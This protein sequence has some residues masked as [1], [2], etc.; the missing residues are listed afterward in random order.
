MAT[1]KEQLT[2]TEFSRRRILGAVL[3]PR[4]GEVGEGVPRPFRAYFVAGIVVVFALG[5]AAVVGYMNPKP[6][7]A[8]KKGLIADGSG[9][10]YVMLDGRLHPLLNGT[11]ARLLFGSTTKPVRPGDAQLAPYLR[12]LGPAVGLAKVPESLPSAADLDLKDFSACVTPEGKT[13]VEVGFPA[14][15]GPGLL[16]G[17]DALL[18]QDDAG[19][20]WVVE[21]GLKYRIGDRAVVAAAFATNGVHPRRVPA[22]WLSGLS[23]GDVLGIPT[24][25]GPYGGPD[26]RPAPAGFDKIG[27]F[28]KTFGPG[29]SVADYFLVTGD[30]VAAVTPTMYELYQRD[31]RLTQYKFTEAVLPAGKVTADMMVG[32]AAS[33]TLAWPVAPPRFSAEWQDAGTSGAAVVCATFAGTFDQQGRAHMEVAVRGALPAGAAGGGAAA[34]AASGGGSADLPSAVVRAGHGVIV[35]ESGSDPATA[36]E[37]LLADTGLRYELV[38]AAP[39]RLGYDGI[40]SCEVPAQWLRLVP[41]GTALDPSRA[42]TPVG[43]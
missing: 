22:A 41:L 37:Y 26:P 17:P 38:D 24:I 31:P 40:A 9:T 42:A 23:A 12:E 35:R 13:V 15:S 19:Q 21:D 8:W 36:P 27:M 2:A 29:G 39:L 28:G 20:Q 32:T 10:E 14:A 33:Q 3:R 7:D 16:A 18:V 34:G 43:S 30:G 4:A 1:R 25:S 11:S 5:T 6:K